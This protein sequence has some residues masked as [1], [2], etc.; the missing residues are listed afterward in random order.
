VNLQSGTL[1]GTGVISIGNALVSGGEFVGNASL[2]INTATINAF[3]SNVGFDQTKVTFAGL[4]RI[5]TAT[6]FTF[7]NDAKLQI[8][9]SS[10][11]IQNGS[12]SIVAGDSSAPSVQVDGGWASSD[13][14]SS[15]IDLTGKGVYTFSS[16]AISTNNVEFEAS[17]VSL[18]PQAN[19]SITN[20]NVNIA[21]VDGAG[22]FHVIANSLKLG[23]V[24]AA[25]FT[26]L[27]G[28]TQFSGPVH[29]SNLNLQS[30]KFLAMAGV[31][32]DRT[33]NFYGGEIA[34][35]V[36]VIANTVAF[37]GQDGKTLTGVA[38]S[39]RNI[40]FQCGGGCAVLFSS[41]AT[42]SSLPC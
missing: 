11:L 37:V 23:K 24:T 17:R 21:L 5:P 30:G 3:G 32:I 31:Q 41:N 13:L 4:V 42:L 10:F 38:L 19:V 6:Q 22:N 20:G 1:G 40:L 39:A 14:L 8:A 9:P 18:G 7:K 25:D 26:L 36:P 15:N 33:L 35:S 12:V 34:G 2:Y 28:V 29:L 16:G 27:S